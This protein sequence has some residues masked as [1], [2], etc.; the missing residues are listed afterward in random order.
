MRALDTKAARLAKH[1]AKMKAKRERRKTLVA[2][3]TPVPNK[4]LDAARAVAGLRAKLA[5]PA[6]SPK[7]AEEQGFRDFCSTLPRG[8][9]FRHLFPRPSKNDSPAYRKQSAA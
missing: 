9:P 6:L 1:K 3:F 5:N 4:K 2:G 8:R 7:Q